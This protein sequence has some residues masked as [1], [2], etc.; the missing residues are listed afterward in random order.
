MCDAI[1]EIYATTWWK[2]NILIFSLIQKIWNLLFLKLVK[3]CLS[4]PYI[5]NYILSKLIKNKEKQFSQFS[6]KLPCATR[7]RFSHIA[8]HMSSNSISHNS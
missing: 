2:S 3:V 6:A 5:Q 1:W 8:S 7:G 4:D